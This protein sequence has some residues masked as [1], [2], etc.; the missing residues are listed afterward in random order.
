M[1]QR[2]IALGWILRASEAWNSIRLANCSY[3][4]RFGEG[5]EHRRVARSQLGP[6]RMR[7]RAEES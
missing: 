3:D 4:P 2:H 7:S 1:A 5:N 6:D